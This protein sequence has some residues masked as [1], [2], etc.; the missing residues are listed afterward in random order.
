M[1]AGELA[2]REALLNWLESCARPGL[3]LT[4]SATGADPA[5]KKARADF[6]P[7]SVKFGE[8]IERRIG[9][10][11]ELRSI[12]N[13][14]MEIFLRGS[15]PPEVAS[16]RGGSDAGSKASPLEDKESFFES[17]PTEDFGAAEE[18]CREALLNYLDGYAGSG[19]A[20]L[21]EAEQ[22]DEIARWRREL[23]P[24]GCPVKLQEWI[25]RRI[26]GEIETRTEPNGK[27]VFGMRGMLPNVN[28][29]GGGAAKRRKM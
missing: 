29:G 10:E 28:G 21:G 15:A 8:W 18:G 24:K 9:G 6:L 25:D 1:E 22:E 23:L 13:G 27:V 7:K 16:P 19:P 3:T 17:L 4:L 12:A 11:V 26:G 20:V 14:Q 2:L 5:I